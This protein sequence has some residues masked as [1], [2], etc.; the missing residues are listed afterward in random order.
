MSLSPQRVALHLIPSD[1][2]DETSDDYEGG[3]EYDGDG[4]V[5]IYALTDELEGRIEYH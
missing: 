3:D 1:A 2:T 4:Y 5:H